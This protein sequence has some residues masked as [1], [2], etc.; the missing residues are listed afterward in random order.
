[1]ANYNSKPTNVSNHQ[2][3]QNKL[4]QT[5]VVLKKVLEFWIKRRKKPEN[6]ALLRKYRF[7]WNFTPSFKLSY[8]FG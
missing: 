6:N 8:R 5:D 3:S 2:L 4:E 1:M 7:D